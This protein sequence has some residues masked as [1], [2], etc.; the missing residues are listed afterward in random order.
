MNQLKYALYVYNETG[1]HKYIEWNDLTSL[2]RFE[3]GDQFDA[4]RF[5]SASD[6][7]GRFVVSDAHYSFPE[8]EDREI[9]L[10]LRIRSE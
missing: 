5:D 6:M 7:N 4:G 3:V 2:P 1:D 8:G 10:W 9:I